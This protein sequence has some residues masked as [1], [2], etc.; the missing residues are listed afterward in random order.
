MLTKAKIP[1][2]AAIVL[3]TAFSAFAA[4]KSRGPHANPTTHNTAVNDGTVVRSLETHFAVMR[5]C[6]LAHLAGHIEIAR[7]ELG[8]SGLVAL[9][10][11]QALL[12]ECRNLAK[13]PGATSLT[14]AMSGRFQGQFSYSARSI[15]MSN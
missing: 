7:D 13:G 9:Y 2:C 6:R 5:V 11:G 10:I 12:S 14:A 1:L 3:C 15:R 4:A 8:G